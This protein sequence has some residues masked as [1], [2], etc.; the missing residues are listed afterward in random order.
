MEVEI[1]ESA[2]PLLL[3]ELQTKSALSASG[4]ASSIK[5]KTNVD[6]FSNVVDLVPASSSSSSA[7]TLLEH[8]GNG[9]DD[10]FPPYSSRSHWSQLTRD[11]NTMGSSMQLGALTGKKDTVAATK[12]KKSNG[13]LHLNDKLS[14]K[15]SI[16]GSSN[17][18]GGGGVNGAAN[19]GKQLW[20]YERD[21]SVQPFTPEI[22][23]FNAT[24]LPSA[25]QL[26]SGVVLSQGESLVEGPTRIESPNTMSRKRFDVSVHLLLWRWW[27]L[28][29]IVERCSQCLKLKPYDAFSC[30]RA[31]RPT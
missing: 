18:S 30:T 4:S 9:G 13:A 5:M 2:P 29:N 10:H 12:T 17:S 20:K 23:D 3:K 19:G 24:A 6:S 25:I 26:S 28:A 8:G 16:M 14:R 7:A 21:G 1:V 11:S 31:S 15:R 22:S 27:L